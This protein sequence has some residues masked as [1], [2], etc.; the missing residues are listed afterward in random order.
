VELPCALFLFRIAPL[1]DSEVC[2][3]VDGLPCLSQLN[4]VPSRHLPVLVLHSDPNLPHPEGDLRIMEAGGNNQLAE[5]VSRVGLY[6]WC[7]TRD[8]YSHP[9]LPLYRKHLVALAG[10]QQPPPIPREALEKA[11]SVRALREG[12][13]WRHVHPTGAF[14]IGPRVG[15][16]I[17]SPL[18]SA[19]KVCILPGPS[20]RPCETRAGRAGR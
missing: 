12:S 1:L 2:V 4:I 16:L 6:P 14:T 17:L 15:R 5:F 10:G 9:C 8:K 11:S 7:T 20:L 13:V 19:K 18:P 3:A